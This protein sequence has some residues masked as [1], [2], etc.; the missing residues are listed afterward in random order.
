MR[1]YREP[2]Q[3]THSNRP[4]WWRSPVWRGGLPRQPILGVA[5]TTTT[6]PPRPRRGGPQLR[7]TWLSAGRPGP[8]G[9]RTTASSSTSMVI[10]LG[11][12]G[13]DWHGKPSE[14]RDAGRGRDDRRR[15]ADVGRCRRAVGRRWAGTA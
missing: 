8:T 1:I 5:A 3:W 13:A 2:P 12:N 14:R 10:F 15:A 11:T 9:T 7:S 4:L 6:D